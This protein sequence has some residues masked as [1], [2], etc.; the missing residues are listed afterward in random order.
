MN[1][2]VKKLPKKKKKVEIEKPSCPKCQAGLRRIEGKHG[3]FWSCNNFR[4]GCKFTTQDHNEKPV[5]IFNCP[6]CN[7]RL[8]RLKT[9]ERYFWG[10]SGYRNGCKTTFSDNNGEPVLDKINKKTTKTK[11]KLDKEKTQ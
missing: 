9:E 8:R 10:C 7:Q 1:E 11:D 4:D 5:G 2:E 3:F 6:E